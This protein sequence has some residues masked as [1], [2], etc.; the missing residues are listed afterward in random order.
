VNEIDPMGLKEKKKYKTGDICI[1]KMKQRINTGSCPGADDC[2]VCC[3]ELIG[4]VEY[5][6]IG[7]CEATC[8]AGIEAYKKA[9][10]KCYKDKKCEDNK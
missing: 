10:G 8:V 4:G 5:L 6:P 1:E 3:A 9:T 2:F 7:I